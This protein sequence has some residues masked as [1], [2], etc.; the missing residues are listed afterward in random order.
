MKKIL[1]IVVPTYN[2]QD[3]L[4]KC[5]DSLIVSEEQMKQLEVLVINDGSKDNSSVIAHNYQNKYPN[6]FIVIDKENGNY[7]SCINVGLAKA[8][9]KYFRILDADD[10]FDTEALS[11]LLHIIANMQKDVDMICTNYD[12]FDDKGVCIE[13]HSFKNIHY[14][15]ITKFDEYDLYDLGLSDMIVMHA[16]TY[17]TSLLHAIN[18][19]QQTGISY[20]DTEFVFIP[21]L[22]VETVLFLDICLYRYLIGRVGQTVAQTVSKRRTEQY[23]KVASRLLSIYKEYYSRISYSRR[24]NVSCCLFNVIRSYFFYSLVFLPKE[25]E[26]EIRLNDL[27]HYIS[28]I[29][30]ALWE[31]LIGCRQKRIPYI[32]IWENKGYYLSESWLFRICLFIKKNI[33][34]W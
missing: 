14:G 1:T 4:Q 26:T 18:Y 23:F 25:E 22:S 24:H 9:G 16:I 21:M 17:K 19:S 10:S 8:S 5:L 29:D 15:E 2:M 13:K 32:K 3:Y 27:K 7:G 34:K 20:T 31:R 30:P 12:V 28:S 33:S 6:T 11:K